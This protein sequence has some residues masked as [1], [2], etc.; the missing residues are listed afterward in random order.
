M[1]K[2]LLFLVI[3]N[4]F[5]CEQ[6]FI[7]SVKESIMENNPARFIDIPL[8]IKPTETVTETIE[9]Y[10]NGKIRYN[11]PGEIYGTD[12][13]G[14]GSIP[15]GTSAGTEIEFSCRFSFGPLENTNITIILDRS[16]TNWSVDPLKSTIHFVPKYNAKPKASNSKNL[17]QNDKFNIDITVMS[18][19]T[20]DVNIEDGTFF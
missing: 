3:S 6:Q 10:C 12:T 2:I 13:D 18:A 15:A 7:I 1:I 4:M 20:T 19:V 8:I 14:I 16:L 11:P 9:I 5:Y 17:A